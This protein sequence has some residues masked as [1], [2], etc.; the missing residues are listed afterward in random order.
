MFGIHD[1]S[2]FLVT[3][4]A[5]NL[6]PGPDTV[7]ILGRSVSQGTSAGVASVLGISTGVLIHTFAAT[8]GLS[9][10]ITASAHAFLFLKILGATYLVYIG[11]KVIFSHETEGEKEQILNSDG[12][13]RI[14][15]QGLLT[16]VLNPKVALFF[17]ALM[18]QFIASESNSKPLA[19]IVLGVCF[20]LTGTLWC[21][22]LVWFASNLTKQLRQT[23]VFSKML[24]YV[25]SA[26][27]VSL[28]IRLLVLD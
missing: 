16:N 1:F 19:F 22:C 5:L 13:W 25:S 7:Y 12:F 14:Y 24:K 20:V 2:L 9:A 6:S 21:L 3:A 8:I 18:P 23:S 10:L 11:I 4:I 28:G 27:F 15:R 26:L 17:L